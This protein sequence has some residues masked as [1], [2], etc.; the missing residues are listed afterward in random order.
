MDESERPQLKQFAF[1]GINEAFNDKLNVLKNLAE[2]ENWTSRGSTYENDI[3]YRY[4]MHTFDRIES[5]DKIIY[6]KDGKYASF[7]TGLLTEMGEDIV[8]LFSRNMNP[9]K[10][11]WYLDGFVCLSD[12]KFAEKFNED[13]QVAECFDKPEMMYFN[14]NYKII[15]NI[16]H[17]LGDNIDRFPPKLATQGRNYLVTLFSGALEL[18]K[19]K[20]KRNYRLVVPQYYD[21]RITYLLP[22]VI[23]DF[24]CALA[25]ELLN[26]EQYRANTILTLDMAYSNARLLM[27]P[28]SDWLNI[29][30]EGNEENNKEQE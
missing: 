17:I 19:R 12:R 10:E 20:I 6:T 16:S 9:D 18:T 11:K 13:P 3:L 1:L 27:K 29:N 28:E 14:P 8:A 23:D 24:K 15:V 21:R 7:N 4:V 25:I 22:L 2:K 30:F 26:N 5:E